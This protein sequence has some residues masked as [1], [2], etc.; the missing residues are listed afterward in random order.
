MMLFQILVVLGVF[1]N[2]HTIALIRD[3]NRPVGRKLLFGGG[4]ASTGYMEN[5]TFITSD[6]KEYTDI[7]LTDG[8]VIIAAN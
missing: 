4:N 5:I 8:K 7:E 1:F 6:T 3:I 2:K